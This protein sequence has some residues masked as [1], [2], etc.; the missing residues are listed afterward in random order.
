MRSQQSALTKINELL[1]WQRWRIELWIKIEQFVHV[2][3]ESRRKY[4]HFAK[5]F[6]ELFVICWLYQ[7]KWQLAV[8]S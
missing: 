1:D 6:Y 4:P 7:T 8:A 5:V 3:T 2:G